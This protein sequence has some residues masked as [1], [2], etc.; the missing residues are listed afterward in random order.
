MAQIQ[1]HGGQ[2]LA[3]PVDVTVEQVVYEVVETAVS[4]FW[5]LDGAF[6]EEGPRKAA[7]GLFPLSNAARSYISGQGI[8]VDG[9]YTVQ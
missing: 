4:H 8:V 1:T 2:A 3:L 9:G 6:N 5:R 7:S